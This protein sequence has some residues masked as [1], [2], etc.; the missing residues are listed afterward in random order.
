MNAEIYSFRTS[1]EIME[2]LNGSIDSISAQLK[3]NDVSIMYKTELS[4]SGEKLIEAI[5]LSMSDSA[6]IKMIIMAN[7][8]SRHNKGVVYATLSELNKQELEARDLFY[9]DITQIDPDQ[10]PCPYLHGPASL[11]SF[12]EGYEC[13]MI[14]H[15]GVI[16][17][18]LPKES[19]CGTPTEEMLV[20]A[21]SKART[22]DNTYSNMWDDDLFEDEEDTTDVLAA[23]LADSTRGS[24]TTEDAEYTK[25]KNK[26]KKIPFYKHILPWKGDRP[27]E[28]VRKIILIA[29]VF[30]FI[31][32][33]VKLIR[34]TFLDR[35]IYNNEIDELRNIYH[36]FE[37]LDDDDD[38]NT[39][40]SNPYGDD[41]VKSKWR[42]LYS[43]YPNLVGWIR[44]S[45]S[46]WI[47]LPVFQP[48]ASDPNYYL[49]RDFKGEDN[50][51]GSLFLDTRSSQ[52]VNSKNIIIHG[53]H[54]NDGSMFA[55]ITKYQ[56]MDYYSKSPTITFNTIYSDAE[57][58]VISVFKTNTLSE[59]GEFFNYLRGEF[60]SSSDFLNYVYQVRER[61]VI[62]MPVDV[63]ED[64][65]LLTLSTC[66][67]EFTDFRT[68]VVARR[69]RK[70]EK[71]SVDTSRAYYESNP[72]YPE[73]WYKYNSGTRPVLTSFEEEYAKGNIS[74]YD[75]KGTVE[76]QGKNYIFIDPEDDSSSSKPEDSSSSSKPSSS[77]SSSSSRPVISVDDGSSTVIDI[78]DTPSDN[79]SQSNTSH[80]GESSVPSS[81]QP[82]DGNNSSSKPTSS[83]SPPSSDPEPPSSEE[84]VSSSEPEPPSSEDPEPSSEDPEP[85][86]E[87]PEPS[88]EEPE[89]PDE[90]QPI[91]E[92]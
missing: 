34:V 36:Q 85:S 64:D 17:I 75:G 7:A 42:E 37:L 35:E 54:M 48:P 4:E 25:A 14:K 31:F 53:H 46:K 51:Y 11:C 32:S 27:G 90:T 43:K 23:V 18:A 69:V 72:V 19:E 40:D 21:V 79:D 77:S 81:S 57:W 9:S 88:S 20:C 76:K 50:R 65:Q 82:S 45:F 61:S 41:A 39:T 13:C 83:V 62:N 30:T 91:P 92:G 67:Y 28:V 74:W 44:I 2:K 60:S 16:I 12:G 78:D 66:S 68:V 87:E 55:D 70:G 38:T 6:N 15:R 8:I 29:A 84:P 56:Y 26:K 22:L 3:E 58:K 71:T 52:G 5:K 33:G 73:V 24:E 86:S 80:E 59:H 47:D 89:N 63:N 49:Y 1:N 10:E